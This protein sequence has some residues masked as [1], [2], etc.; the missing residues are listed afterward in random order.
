MVFDAQ[1]Y[2]IFMNYG[3]RIVNYFVTLQAN[4]QINRQNCKS[5]R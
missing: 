5:F 1:K 4:E 2:K 3:L